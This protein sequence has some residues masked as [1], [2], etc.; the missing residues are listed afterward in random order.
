MT[1]RP[2]DTMPADGWVRSCLT[3]AANVRG[4]R[5]MDGV[6]QYRSVH[7]EWFDAD[8]SYDPPVQWWDGSVPGAPSGRY[9]YA[10][11]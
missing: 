7:G 2:I 9:R 6:R 3:R 10:T 1:Y 4:C 8:A 5:V 11:D